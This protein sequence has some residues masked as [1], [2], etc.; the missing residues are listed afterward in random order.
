MYTQNRE[1]EVRLLVCL[2]GEATLEEDRIVLAAWSYA[3]DWLE[4]ESL[5][6]ACTKLS[7][8]PGGERIVRQI[9]LTDE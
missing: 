3:E 1:E 9:M 8:V 4:D 5:Q 2:E 7:G 6:E